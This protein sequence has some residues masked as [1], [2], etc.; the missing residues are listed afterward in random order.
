[1]NL[2]KRIKA[3]ISTYLGRRKYEK[4]NERAKFRALISYGMKVSPIEPGTHPLH[5][6]R[7]AENIANL[8]QIGT[9]KIIPAI[10]IHDSILDIPRDKYDFMDTRFMFGISG[11]WAEHNHEML[12]AIKE[13]LSTRN[14]IPAHVI[15]GCFGNALLAHQDFL[16]FKAAVRKVFDAA[17][18]HWPG[19]KII[20]Y[21]LPPV[22][23]I[24]TNII[25]WEVEMFFA[26]L[27]A[28]DKNSCFVS[29]KEFGVG[30]GRLFPSLWMST[31][32]IHL[33]DKAVYEL[34]QKFKR[35]MKPGVFLA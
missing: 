14:L 3:I 23:D 27:V 20:L 18:G 8:D 32:G 5:E 9:H 28:E 29:L 12:F 6:S 13:E 31:D 7:L 2:F 24:Y 34:N 17:R 22:W 15:I 30:F 33:T 25:A 26:Q 16:D 21:G 10:A 4:M 1:M 35:A 11:S 19:S